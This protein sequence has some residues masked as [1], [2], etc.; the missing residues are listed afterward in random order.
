MDSVPSEQHNR[1]LFFSSAI[2]QLDRLYKF[3]RHQL[4]YLES[5]GDL[6]R[7]ELTGEDVVDTVLLRAY[8]EFVKPSRASG[9]TPSEAERVKQ[10]AEPDIGE[11][12][13]GLA[14]A[15]IERDVKRF[16]AER[17]R[18]VHIEEDVPETPP[19][20]E[21]Q[22]LGDEILDFYVSDED[23]KLEDVFPDGDVDASL[24]LEGILDAPPI[25][26][27]RSTHGRR[28]RGVH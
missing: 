3:V 5:V 2:Q 17:K 25:P 23:L 11:W 24:E 26:R 8:R 10:P 27:R 4:A 28:R 18:T 14:K 12:L 15:Q 13:I 9:S 7:G 22:T 19:A 21:V 20:E 1:E 16:K 6:M